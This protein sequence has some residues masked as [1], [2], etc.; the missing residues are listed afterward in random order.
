MIYTVSIPRVAL[1]L[2]LGYNADTP[3]RGLKFV[4]FDVKLVSD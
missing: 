1:P 2:T 4:L 3:I